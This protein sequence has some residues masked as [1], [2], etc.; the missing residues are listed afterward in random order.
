MRIIFQAKYFLLLGLINFLI[1]NLILQISLF[2]LPIWISTLISQSTNYLL[3]FNLY[4]KFVFKKSILN[5]TIALKYI[6]ISIFSWIINTLFIYLIFKFSSFNEGLAAIMVIPIIVI[7]S[8]L[9]QKYYV[10]KK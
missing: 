3:G 1:T 4:G 2:F 5:K 8:F 10:F 6:L 9:A 7:Y